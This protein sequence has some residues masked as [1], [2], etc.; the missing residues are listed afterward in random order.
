MRAATF[1]EATFTLPPE[2]KELTIS[3]QYQFL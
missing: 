3:V 2:G 1:N